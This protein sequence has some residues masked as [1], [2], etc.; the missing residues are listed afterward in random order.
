MPR[1][2][3]KAQPKHKSVT[4]KKSKAGKNA[5]PRVASKGANAAGANRA[6]GI[7]LFTLAGRPSKQDFIT[8]FGSNGPKLTWAQRAAAGVPANKFQAALAAKQSGRKAV[9]PSIPPLTPR[10]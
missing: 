5:K 3:K 9:K 10:D 4:S 6:E 1:S 2:R 8:V 7:R